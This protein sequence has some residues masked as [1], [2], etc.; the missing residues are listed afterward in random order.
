MHLLLP[1]EGIIW[2]TL[3]SFGC[4]QLQACTGAMPPF[5][6]MQACQILIQVPVLAGFTPM[7]SIAQFSNSNLMAFQLTL[8]LLRKSMAARFFP[9]SQDGMQAC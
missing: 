3:A 4:S 1:T 9:A 2:H 5:K 8:S 7:A 6:A